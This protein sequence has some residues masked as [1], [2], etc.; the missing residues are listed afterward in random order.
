MLEALTM[1]EIRPI[2]ATDADHVAQWLS[3]FEMA[4]RTGGAAAL[5]SLFADECHWRDM[6]AFTWTVTPHEDRESIVDDL[7]R[8]QP[9][10]N[11]RNFRIAYGRTPPRRVKRVG[12]DV[13]E[14]IFSFE[15]EIGRCH[16]ILRL[17]IQSPDKAWVF[18]T[19][20]TELKGYEEPINK[21]R[22]TGSAYS[23][24]FGGANWS[25]LRKKTASRQC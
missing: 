17:P 19:S 1:N 23:R 21:R 14:A 20:L 15:T 13:I 18:S 22:P 9:R 11:A 3:E 6:L 10:A 7:L 4:L 2:S 25:D 5:A 8:T 16:G 24:N 12:V